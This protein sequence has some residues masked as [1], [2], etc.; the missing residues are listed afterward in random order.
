MTSKDLKK[1]FKEHL[2]PKKLYKVG[3]EKN[4]RI[5]LEKCG[6][7][8]EVF[9]RDHKKKLGLIRYKDEKSACEGM[10][11]EIRKLMESIYGITWAGNN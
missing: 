11:N 10:M 8:W 7:Y 1:F 6:E 2:V 5:C 3:G 4:N 9:F